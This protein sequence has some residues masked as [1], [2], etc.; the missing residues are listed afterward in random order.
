M[1]LTTRLT[2][3]F[4]TLSE[5]LL[6]VGIGAILFALALGIFAYLGGGLLGIVLWMPLAWNTAKA[7]ACLGL[8]LGACSGLVN[9]LEVVSATSDFVEEVLDVITD[10]ELFSMQTVVIFLLAC[11]ALGRW[12]F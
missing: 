3:A 7:G 12:L 8:V 5:Y 9:R 2:H 1:N 6:S 11:A 4:F 10:W